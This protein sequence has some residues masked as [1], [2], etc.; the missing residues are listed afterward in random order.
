MIKTIEVEIAVM[1]WMGI[2]ANL[3]VPNVSWGIS[4]KYRSLHECDIISL[5]R[6]GFA[7]EVEIKVSKHDLL[8]DGDKKHGHKHNL[9]ANLYFAVPEKLKELALEV[10][11]ERAGLLVVE[12]LDGKS[13]AKMVRSPERNKYCIKWDTTKRYQLARL[14]TMRILGLKEKILK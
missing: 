2:R 1:R 3:V 4:D 7:T 13:F 5:S 9:I 14:G 8:K 6:S 11:P 12:K 10:I